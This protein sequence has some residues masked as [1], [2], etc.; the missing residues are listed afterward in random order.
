MGDIFL[1]LS[2][3][4]VQGEVQ[5][6]E[7]FT[8]VLTDT[9][10]LQTALNFPVG[11]VSVPTT[12]ILTPTLETAPVGLRFAGH[13]FDL[14]LLENGVPVQPLVPVQIT[15]QY[16]GA[17]LLGVRDESQLDLYLWQN[18][19]WLP[20]GETCNP[21]EPPQANTTANLFSQTTCHFSRFSL[22]GPGEGAIYLPLALK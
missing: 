5:P 21:A 3:L 20:A 1:R 22:F 18:G 2:L 19:N 10:G 17:D 4:P 15:I 11:S 13:A 7:S 12:A 9:A 6:G 14:S 8:L 16:S